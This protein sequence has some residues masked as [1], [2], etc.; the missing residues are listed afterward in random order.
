[1]R[2]LGLVSSAV[3]TA[4]IELEMELASGS[5]FILLLK[6]GSQRNWCVHPEIFD[7]RGKA[8]VARNNWKNVGYTHGAYFDATIT[9]SLIRYVDLGEQNGDNS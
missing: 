6:L 4:E 7:S 8:T 5:G 2:M 1:M 3:R 9:K